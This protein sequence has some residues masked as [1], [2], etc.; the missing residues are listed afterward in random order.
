MDDS[1]TIERIRG[2]YLSDRS[3]KAIAA[4]TGKRIPVIRKMLVDL[5]RRRVNLTSDQI[6]LIQRFDGSVREVARRV[7]CS[8]STVA[9]HRQ[10]YDERDSDNEDGT[11]DIEIEFERLKSPR[12]CPEHG[13][14]MVWPCPVCCAEMA[15][16]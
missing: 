9:R 4:E 14:V 15:N 8:K 7:G 6:E 3:L 2:L 13:L 10:I 11:I 1:A 12:R 16:E 5:P